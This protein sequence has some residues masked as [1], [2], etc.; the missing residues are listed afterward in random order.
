M[1]CP[2]FASR[3]DTEMDLRHPRR[4]VTKVLREFPEQ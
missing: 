1:L 2:L 3:L 4:T